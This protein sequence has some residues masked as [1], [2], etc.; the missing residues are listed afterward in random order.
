MYANNLLIIG[1]AHNYSEFQ[2]YRFQ[3]HSVA[4]KLGS[5][6]VSMLGFLTT[7]TNSYFVDFSCL[8]VNSQFM[9]HSL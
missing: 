8:K 3:A 4:S 5:N 7:L 1:L 6:Y 9:L 2:I